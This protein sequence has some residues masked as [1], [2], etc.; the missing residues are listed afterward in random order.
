[1]SPN[2]DY[3]I[4]GN[5]NFNSS[6]VEPH[7]NDK[8]YEESTNKEPN[9]S[10]LS[11]NKKLIDNIKTQIDNI[12]ENDKLNA[13]TKK[14]KIK[15]LKEELKKA[16]EV[17]KERR[18]EELESANQKRDERKEKLDKKNC[19]NN[20]NYQSTDG[21]K[22]T[23][24][25]QAS[26]LIKVESRVKQS[27]H[28]NLAKIELENTKEILKNEINM[29]QKLGIN[30]SKKEK[31]LKKLEDRDIR[32]N[33]LKEMLL[34]QI[35]ADNEDKDKNRHNNVKNDIFNQDSKNDKVKFIS[36]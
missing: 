9:D 33:N 32:I 16:K 7:I 3:A 34:E 15:E 11:S 19:P 20:Q 30:T 36:K 14:L 29:D 23:I 12:K 1:M 31:Q 5:Y 24:S 28:D 22:L 4:N 10:T 6:T 13:E 18:L 27:E 35:N 25:E 2:T 17:E 21:D 26:N 8:V